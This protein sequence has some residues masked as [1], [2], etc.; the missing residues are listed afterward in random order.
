MHS[1]YEAMGFHFTIM[2]FTVIFQSENEITLYNLCFFLCI[3]F[4]CSNIFCASSVQIWRSFHK[5]KETQCMW[6][7]GREQSCFVPLQKPGHVC[8]GFEITE[9]SRNVTLQLKLQKCKKC[10]SSLNYNHL[11]F[12]CCFFSRGGDLPLDLQWVPSFHVHRQS[13]ICFSEDRELVHLQ[14]GSSGCRKLLLLC[15][16]PRYWKKRLF[17]VHPPHPFTPWRWLVDDVAKQRPWMLHYPLL[18]V[19]VMWDIFNL[20][21]VRRGSI[22]QTSEWNSQTQQPCW[23]LILHWSVLLWESKFY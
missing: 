3:I 23:R 8:T 6:K 22:L 1:L 7:K 17:Q 12:L 9:N 11:F 10:S 19:F 15:F 20:M 14:G 18:S 16:Q 4:F 5:R 2:L 21:Q 13:P